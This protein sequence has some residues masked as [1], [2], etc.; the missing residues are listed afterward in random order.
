MND[1]RRI[2]IEDI[3]DGDREVEVDGEERDILDDDCNEE[4]GAKFYFILFLRSF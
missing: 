4:D 3:D 1:D 2:L